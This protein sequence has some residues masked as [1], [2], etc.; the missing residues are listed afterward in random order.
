MLFSFQ[1]WIYINNVLLIYAKI[2]H[3]KDLEGFI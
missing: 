1:P 3:D 2:K